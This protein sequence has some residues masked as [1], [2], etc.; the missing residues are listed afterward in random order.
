[1]SELGA[2]A[3]T[4]PIARTGLRLTGHA[5]RRRKRLTDLERDADAGAWDEF[6][7]A[8][9]ALL[10]SP[11]LPADHEC[12]HLVLRHRE[13]MKLWFAHYL[14]WEL[15]AD[16][17][18]CRLVKRPPDARD[19]TRPCRVPGTK[20]TAFSRRAY[21]FLCLVLGVL[22][23]TGRQIT[24]KHL[25]DRLH[26]V[27]Q[28]EPCFEAQGLSL[29]LD[30]REVRRDLVHAL[31]LLIAWEALVR[32]DGSEEG[33]VAQQ[34]DVLYTVQ[35]A[36]LSRML[37]VRHPPSL[38]DAEDLETRLRVLRQGTAEATADGSE[39]W[40]TREIGV[41]LR[42]RLIDD[43]VMYYADLSP[44][45]LAYLDKQRA[46]LLDPLEQ[47]TGLVPEV[48]AEGIAM[49]DRGGDLSDYHLPETGTNGHLTLLLATW[50]AEHLR[51][52]PDALVPVHVLEEE[53]AR[54]AAANPRWRKDARLPGAEKTLTRDTLRRLEALALVRVRPL[55]AVG[56]YGLRAPPP[57]PKP[58][59]AQ[60]TLL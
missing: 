43:P 8:V 2:S 19:A 9:R 38:I 17:E 50:L 39:H 37:A 27:I 34:E 44:D 7:Q 51:R 26:G 28:A 55:P 23:E 42:R 25:A 20:D 30:Q 32:I 57:D 53:T 13:W 40:R 48:R 59:V 12:R 16:S 18:I 3:A 15:H 35:H 24:L 11:L 29:N 41:R 14:D 10:A 45:E 36:V 4:T 5:R 46:Q 47:A 6:R 60:E 52:E 33:F 54:L 56:R 21:V 49:V 58:E 31:R 22:I 1:M